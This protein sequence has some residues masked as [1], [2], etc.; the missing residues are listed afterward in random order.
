M[1]LKIQLSNTDI[2]TEKAEKIKDE[3][4]QF[5]V[6]MLEELLKDI[7]EKELRSFLATLKKIC[8]AMK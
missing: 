4:K 7:D 3:T 8:E 5:G 2:L 6:S 1:L